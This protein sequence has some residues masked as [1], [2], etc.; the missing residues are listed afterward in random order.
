MFRE[1]LHHQFIQILNNV[2]VLCVSNKEFYESVR[3]KLTKKN[4]GQRQLPKVFA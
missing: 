3:L 4:Q 2:S 1:I